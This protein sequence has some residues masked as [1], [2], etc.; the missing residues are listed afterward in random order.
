MSFFWDFYPEDQFREM[1]E[2][3]PAYGEDVAL[4]GDPEKIIQQVKSEG[5]FSGSSTIRETIEIISGNRRVTSRQP[6]NK[7]IP[8][9]IP[10]VKCYMPRRHVWVVPLSDPIIIYDE[11]STVQTMRVPL[12]KWDA[13][14]DTDKW[15]GM[16]TPKA[17]DRDWETT[18]TCLRG[19]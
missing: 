5:R 17:G 15:F 11:E 2:N 6:S 4:T 13:W 12:V 3:Q 7:N 1:F 9:Q 10:V 16:S 14:P 19:I 18:Q 8:I